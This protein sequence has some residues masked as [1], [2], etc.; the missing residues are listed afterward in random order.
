[1]LNTLHEKQVHFTQMFSLL[2]S[3][4]IQL[5]LEPVID[6]VARTPEQQRWYVDH[7]QSKTMS[8]RHLQRLA[9]DLLLFKNGTYLTTKPD[10]TPLGQYWKSLDPLN[11]WGGDWGW[12]ANHFEYG[13]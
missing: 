6:E 12:D 4:A 10:Y 11:R 1:M 2:I 7:G 9:G 8:S 5:G 3:K 13:G